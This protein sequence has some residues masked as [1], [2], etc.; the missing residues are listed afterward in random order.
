MKLLR[1]ILTIFLV[2]SLALPPGTLLAAK[3]SGDSRVPAAEQTADPTE[4]DISAEKQDQRSESPWGAHT[5]TAA[6]N[7]KDE[8]AKAG[9]KILE[10]KYVT[11]DFDNVDIPVFVKF[12]SEITGKNFVIDNNVRGKVTIFSPHQISIDEAYK[13]FESVLEVH[14]F[15]TIPSGNVIKIIPAKDAKE[16]NIETRL[17]KSNASPGDKIVSQVMSLS[18][19]NPDEM[20]KVLDPLISRNSIILSY[21]PTGM[22]IVTDF[23]SNINRL[24]AIVSALDVAGVG[25]QISVMPLKHAAAGEVG[26]NLG[27]IFQGD[28]QAQQQHRAG[29]SAPVKILADERT[30]SLIVAANE[31]LTHRIKQLV[32]ML[33][34]EVPRGEASIRVYRLKYAN[35]EDLAK[36]LMNLPKDVP[37][38]PKA[39][40]EKG[41]APPISKDVV[42]VADKATNSLVI[43]ATRDDYNAL[44]DII[45]RLDVNR[46]MVYIEALIME[47]SVNRNLQIGVEWRTFNNLGKAPGFDT[48]QLGVIAGSGGAGAGGSY[49][50]IPDSSIVNG[51]TTAVSSFPGGFSLGVL[52]AGLSIGGVNFPNIGAVVQAMQTDDDIHILSTP[53]ILTIDNEDAEIFVGQNIPFLTSQQQNT[54]STSGIAFNSYEFRDVGVGLKLTPH[55]TEADAVRLKIDQT[56]QQLA[57]TT[58]TTGLKT[59]L[60]RTAKTSVLVKDQETVVIGGIIGDTSENTRYKVPCLGDLPLLGYLFKS[61]VETRSKTNLFIFI[62]PHIVRAQKDL[63]PISK[64]KRDV[65]DEAV[66]EGTINLFN[67]DTGRTSKPQTNAPAEGKPAAPSAGTQSDNKPV[68]PPAGMQSDNKPDNS[69]SGKQ[70]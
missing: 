46:P 57:N 35:A 24:Q 23:Q 4:K 48:G 17:G 64:Q 56:V 27:L 47:V 61:N 12:I 65:M 34:Q 3:I 54:A 11:I 41:K 36:I 10:T 5:R 30:N 63:E 8:G 70:N 38:D 32:N 22:L 45:S 29:V 40:Q 7:M 62:T 31:G 69:A 49:T 15:T 18:Y 60:K 55:I 6:K 51:V 50:I 9:K 53:Q 44:S 42:I 66:K 58:D 59:T 21:P 14:G 68:T 20:K 2:F 25:E 1:K 43:T 39:A 26:R 28:A 13:V 19:A 67:K 33:D 52:G 37:K 16:K